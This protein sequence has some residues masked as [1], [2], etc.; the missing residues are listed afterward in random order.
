MPT[1]VI[2]LTNRRDAVD[3]AVLRPGRLEVQVEV[4]KPDATGRAAILTIHTD[5]MKQSGRLDLSASSAPAA[6][7]DDGEPDATVDDDD[8]SGGAAD[9]EFAAWA[10]DV[11]ART[12]GFS[13]AAIAALARAATARAL[14]RAI[15][16][17]KNAKG[18]KV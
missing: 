14:D 15:T 1:L 4:T 16:V 7:D 8:G 13:G 17:E 18:T 2:G 12:E 11:A 3:D 10:R 9:A 5:A 6:A